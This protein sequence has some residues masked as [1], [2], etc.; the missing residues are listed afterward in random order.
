MR[1]LVLL[2]ILIA[3]VPLRAWAGDAM[4][5]QMAAQTR[6][7]DMVAAASPPPAHSNCHEMQAEPATAPQTSH[8]A[9]P[10]ATC[11]S[12]QACFT[13]ALVVPALQSATQALPH[14]LP[15]AASAQFTSAVLALGH[16]PP[17]S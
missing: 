13:V 8:T 16:K 4:A 2:L 14:G 17:I 15:R 12:C 9:D 11:A 7:A 3:L 6:A 1:R 10:C 5:I